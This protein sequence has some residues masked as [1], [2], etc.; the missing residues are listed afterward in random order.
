M[1]AREYRTTS[2]KMES[3]GICDKNTLKTGF[4]IETQELM[5]LGSEKTFFKYRQCG[6]SDRRLE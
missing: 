2:D 3:S 4:C 1:D 6:M 5:G